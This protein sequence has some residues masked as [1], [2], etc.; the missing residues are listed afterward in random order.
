MKAET[1]TI[2]SCGIFFALIAPVYWILT[3]DPTGSTALTDVV[4]RSTRSG[5]SARW[6]TR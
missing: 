5:A 6:G 3:K 4:F 2:L 1:W